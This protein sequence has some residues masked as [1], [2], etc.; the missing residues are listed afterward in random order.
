MLRRRLVSSAFASIPRASAA[1]CPT[2]QRSFVR[3][4]ATD[5]ALPQRYEIHVAP[6]P[7][8]G[9]HAGPMYITERRQYWQHYSSSSE[10]YRATRFALGILMASLFLSLLSPW[11]ILMPLLFLPFLGPVGLALLPLLML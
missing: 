6:S 7:W 8:F 10:G 4:Q 3:D 5:P 11:F 2:M 9:P 1:A